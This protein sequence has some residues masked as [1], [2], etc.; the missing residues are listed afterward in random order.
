MKMVLV[1]AL[2]L[3][4]NVVAAEGKAGFLFAYHPKSTVDFE[5]GYRAH[6]D[7]HRERADPL[8]W[9]G[10]TVVSGERVGLFVD[11]TFGLDFA[12][13]RKRIAPAEDAAHFSRTTAPHA[14]NA[15]RLILALESELG[16][17]TPLETRM[18]SAYVEALIYSVGPGHE[19]EFEDTLRQLAQFAREMPAKPEYAVYRVV[20]GIPAA[21]LVLLARDDYADFDETHPIGS[22]SDIMGL[23]EPHTRQDLNDR[24]MHSVIGVKGETWRYR[25]DL[26]YFPD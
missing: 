3:A 20:S 9:Y 6:L 21:Y 17:A 24:L 18:P 7:W 1:L 15:F 16:T 25:E 13:Y 26:S 22:L 8:S 11:G 2:L 23:L 5:A 4:G 12:D 19:A 14:D 10:W